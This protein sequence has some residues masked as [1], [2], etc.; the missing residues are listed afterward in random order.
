MYHG[1]RIIQDLY[2]SVTLLVNV[3]N[4]LSI[5]SVRF[6]GSGTLQAESFKNI[7]KKPTKQQLQEI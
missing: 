7:S 4:T 3:Q 2:P 6:W 5:S 1:K